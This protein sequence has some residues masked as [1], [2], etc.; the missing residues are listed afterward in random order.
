MRN[1]EQARERQQFLQEAI[2]RNHLIEKLKTLKTDA[3]KNAMH[4]ESLLLD[5][6]IECI[7]NRDLMKPHLTFAERFFRKIA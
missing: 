4:A 1:L 7:T 6:L 2:Y 5:D 3:E